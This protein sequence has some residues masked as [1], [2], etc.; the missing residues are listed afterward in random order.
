MG[1]P[2][3][4]VVALKRLLEKN[5]EPVLVVT[6]P[7]KP[8]GRKK[9]ISPS[10]VK[11][12]ALKRGLTILQ[13]FRL[14]EIKDEIKKINPDLIV[15]AAYGHI[16]PKE[17]FDMPKHKTLNIHPSLLPKYRGPSPIQSTIMA[18][19][20]KTGVTIIKID[21]E[22]DHGPILAQKVIPISPK[23]V[24]K[25][26]EE[27]LAKEGAD[28]LVKII[29]KWFKG[30]VKPKDQDDLFASFTK[31]IEKK[32]GKIDWNNSTATQIE[33]NIRALQ[34]WPSSYTYWN[35]EK[36]GKKLIKILEAETADLSSEGTPGKVFSNKKSKMVV[37][38]QEGSL[39]I[40]KLQMEGKNLM[41]DKEFIL[42]HERFIG[43]I[44]T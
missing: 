21:N 2:D 11:T 17:I 24:Y 29:P 43:T 27:K 1:T 30:K 20:I 3:F 16:L 12:F 38:C 22:I 37:Q 39:V 14:I 42:G 34:P 28:L 41:T 15:V 13:P 10:P 19:E 40:K 44:L 8:V 23:V 18:G 36:K 35:Q 32:D 33:R 31:I 5:Y 25:D 6:A 26:L 4:G 9:I 7:D